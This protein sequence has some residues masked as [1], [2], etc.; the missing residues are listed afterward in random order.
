M[1]NCGMNFNLYRFFIKYIK[2]YD[3]QYHFVNVI[4][5]DQFFVE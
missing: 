1:S 3:I 4:L 2:V 5:L